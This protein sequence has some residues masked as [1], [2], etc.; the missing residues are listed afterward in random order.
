MLFL[1]YLDS[2]RIDISRIT[3]RPD[4]P[5]K[6]R[7]TLEPVA[8][9]LVDAVERDTFRTRR[10]RIE[11]DRAGHERPLEVALPVSAWGHATLLTQQTP[12]RLALYP[13]PLRL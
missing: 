2:F 7:V 3:N 5:W 1:I 9:F 4:K 13:E 12:S 6:L 11:R 10:R 8:G